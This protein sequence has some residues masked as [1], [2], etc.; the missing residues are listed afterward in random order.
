MQWHLGLLNQ[1]NLK[2]VIRSAEETQLQMS[3]VTFQPVEQQDC[4]EF[5]L[6][7]VMRT[8]LFQKT[9]LAHRWSILCSFALRLDVLAVEVGESQFLSVYCSSIYNGP[10]K[11]CLFVDLV[12][13]SAFI[14][15]ITEK[16]TSLEQQYY[17]LTVAEGVEVE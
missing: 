9:F 15:C 4:E 10:L 11:L 5:C 3:R 13:L 16:F 12:F 6:H 7:N 8:V 14:C 17:L 2:L 1:M